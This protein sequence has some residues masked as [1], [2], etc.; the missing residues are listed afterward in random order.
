MKFFFFFFLIA[1]L[2]ILYILFCHL[3]QRPHQCDLCPKAFKHKH[4]L[5]EH[6]RLHT[7][8]KPFQCKKCLKRFSH[9]GSYSQHMN[10]RFSYCKPY[11]EGTAGSPASQNAASEA[12]EPNGPLDQSSSSPGPDFDWQK[13]PV[14]S[15]VKA[16]QLVV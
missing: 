9:S 15:L 8:E 4:H 5:T 7:G 16:L 3:G 13:P 14:T 12:D 2:L 1:F 10:H 6:K 11:R